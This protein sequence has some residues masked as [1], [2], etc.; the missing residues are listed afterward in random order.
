MFFQQEDKQRLIC[1]ATHRPNFFSKSDTSVFEV[2]SANGRALFLDTND[3]Q[4]TA[5]RVTW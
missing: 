2:F 3:Q 5:M 1:Y 4:E